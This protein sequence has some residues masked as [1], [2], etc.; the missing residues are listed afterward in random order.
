[1]GKRGP[2]PG[3]TT[4]PAMTVG[5]PPKHNQ[6]HRTE[7][8]TSPRR[9]EAAERQR[10]ALELRKS[11]ASYR[12]IRDAL[13]YRTHQTCYEAVKSAL[14]KTLQ[15]PADEVRKLELERLDGLLLAL[16]G[17]IK[18]G[19]LGAIDRA[20]HIMERRARLLGLDA[21]TKTDEQ[22]RYPDGMPALPGPAPVLSESE[23][24]SI[25]VAI[26]RDAGALEMLDASRNGHVV[27]GEAR[28]V[29]GNG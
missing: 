7:S 26:L 5:P 16:A 29:D 17:P 27:E 9:L 24:I 28:A 6:R 25:V 4:G 19:H 10:Q 14:L 3:G 18:A 1:M 12:Q 15:Q 22:H 23:R 8:P 11:G 21:P 20:L 2:K 13:G